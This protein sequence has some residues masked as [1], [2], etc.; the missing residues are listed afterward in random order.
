MLLSVLIA[1]QVIPDLGANPIK[2]IHL[3]GEGELKDQ[4]ANSAFKKM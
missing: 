3:R 2:H 4:I 1:S